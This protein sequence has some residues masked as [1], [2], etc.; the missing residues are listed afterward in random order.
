MMDGKAYYRAMRGHTLVYE[1]LCRIRWEK[2]K[3]WLRVTR[4]DDTDNI[5]VEELT[6]P[7]KRSA[8]VNNG[9]DVIDAV[10]E[11]TTRINQNITLKPLMTDFKKAFANQPNFCYWNQ[12]IE[13]VDIL[14]D[15]NRANR[16]GNWQ[17]HLDSFA[18][19]LPWLTVYDHTKPDG[20][21]LS[22]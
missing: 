20:V 11:L 10:Q 7:F 17:L 3:E 22:G 9:D 12:Y 14:L 4:K 8:K 13:M 21:H 5:E 6:I 2:C 1:A 19:M 15:F 16:E 18:A